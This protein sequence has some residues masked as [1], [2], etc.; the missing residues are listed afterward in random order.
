MR[1]F[2]LIVFAIIMVPILISATT[3]ATSDGGFVIKDSGEGT[4]IAL[5][6]P[7]FL[8]RLGAWFVP[9]EQEPELKSIL[10][11]LGTVSVQIHEG[12]FYTDEIR[13]GD[14]ERRASKLCRGSLEPMIEMY[15][16]DERIMVAARQDRQDR[17]R[18][19]AVLVDEGNESFIQVKLKCKISMQELSVLIN[20]GAIEGI[21]SSTLLIKQ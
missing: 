20:S 19:L 13:E 8:V 6:I 17:V 16:D 2:F 4:K 1:R 21:D 5:T 7:G 18:Q 14:F 15:S 3:I 12:S 10:K 9:G 11:K